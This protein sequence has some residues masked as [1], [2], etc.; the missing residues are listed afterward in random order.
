MECQRK[1][2]F[3]Y[4]LLGISPA[5]NC[6]WPTFR[7]PVSVPSSKAGCTHTVHPAFEDGTDTGFRNVGQLQF[8]AG[9]I[10]KRKYTIFKS[11]RK[12][13]IKKRVLVTCFKTHVRLKKTLLTTPFLPPF[14]LSNRNIPRNPSTYTYCI[15]TKF[16]QLLP[17]PNFFNP[18]DGSSV[19]LRNSDATHN[20]TWCQNSEGY[21]YE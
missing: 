15:H 1:E 17:G 10:P 14:P 6:S 3:V 12:S 8:D 20:T 11:R 7:N 2:Y 4:F 19:F 9:E 5:S 13:E 18:D 21:Q 16:L